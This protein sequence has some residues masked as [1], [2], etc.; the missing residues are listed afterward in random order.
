MTSPDVSA[1]SPSQPD[2]FASPRQFH[3]LLELFSRAHSFISDQLGVQDGH[4]F[5]PLTD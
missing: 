4:D 3:E 5:L 1:L 2:G